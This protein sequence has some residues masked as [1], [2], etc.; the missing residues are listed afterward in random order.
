M[1]FHHDIYFTWSQRMAWVKTTLFYGFYLTAYP[2]R[3]W[4]HLEIHFHQ[5]SLIDQISKDLSLSQIQV[6][7]F[8][9]LKFQMSPISCQTLLLTQEIFSPVWLAPYQNH[10]RVLLCTGPPPL[11][12]WLVQRH[13]VIYR[14]SQHHTM[15]C[16]QKY[17]TMISNDMKSQE[18]QFSSSR[19]DITCALTLAKDDKSIHSAFKKC[20]IG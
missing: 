10:T 17:K 11:C 9:F 6:C 14:N 12:V 18:V 5:S 1:V 8:F 19:L 13:W 16:V 20:L 4:V 7:V 15:Q 2:S 3:S